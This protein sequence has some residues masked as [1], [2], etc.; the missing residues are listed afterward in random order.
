[1]TQCLLH[2][3][4]VLLGLPSMLMM[5]HAIVREPGVQCLGVPFGVAM[6]RGAMSRGVF[7]GVSFFGCPSRGTMSG[8][9]LLG[10]QCLGVSFWE[11]PSGGVLL[12]VSF[13]GCP[14]GG[15]MLL[16]SL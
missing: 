14:S 3:H 11:C 9:A 1:M 16:F 6:S 10:V 8:G 7:L 2:A 5:I 13:W 12:G 15:V 4:P